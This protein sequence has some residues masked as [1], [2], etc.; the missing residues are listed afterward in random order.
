M[1]GQVQI[2][3][4]LREGGDNGVPLVLSDPDAGAAKELRTIADK[5]DR[6]SRG[7]AAC[8]RHQPQGPV[9]RDEKAPPDVRRGL[10]RTDQV[11]SLSKGA[12][13]RSA[14]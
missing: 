2:D 5:L 10:R 4:R 12:S 11:A 9:T 3:P 1:L 8:P 13:R 14:G 6:R 7:L